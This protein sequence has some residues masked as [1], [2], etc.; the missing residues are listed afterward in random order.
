M[1]TSGLIYAIEGH[2]I[3]IAERP[4]RISALTPEASTLAF[5][6]A[7]NTRPALTIERGVAIIGLKGVMEKVAFWADEVSTLRV[8][9]ELAEAV[10]SKQVSSIMLAVDSPGGT[11][12]GVKELGDAIRTASKAKPLVAQ[13]E[14]QAA[15]AAL[16][17]V[18]QAGSIS[19]HSL[20]MVGSIGVRMMLFDES[21]AFEDMGVEPVIIDTGEHKSTGAMGAPVTESQRAELQRMVDVFFGAFKDA[22]MQGR[23]GSGL[24]REALNK[25]ADGRMFIGQEAVDNK[26]IDRVASS[27][28][29]LAEL[30]RIKSNKRQVAEDYQ[31][32]VEAGMI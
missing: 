15:S 32:R 19:A 16:W 21:K 28:Q 24:S 27:E 25:L 29:T 3:Y 12:D 31:R 4:A 23:R 17:A 30:G 7:N 20:D 18:S 13:V 14:G 11:V 22:I 9:H 2:D 8:R 10:N 5:E 26:L 1:K 6:A